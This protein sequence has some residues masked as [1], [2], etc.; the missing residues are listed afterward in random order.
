MAQQLFSLYF[1]S[2]GAVELMC[3]AAHCHLLCKPDCCRVFQCSAGYHLS[4]TWLVCA[5]SLKCVKRGCESE[6]DISCFFPSLSGFLTGLSLAQWAVMQLEILQVPQGQNTHLPLWR[7]ECSS[8]LV[9]SYKHSW[10]MEVKPVRDSILIAAL[11]ES[12]SLAGVCSLSVLRSGGCHWPL[13]VLHCVMEEAYCFQHSRQSV[14]SVY[15][16]VTNGHDHEGNSIDFS[17]LSQ[18]SYYLMISY[19]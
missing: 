6:L 11:C 3:N 14:C 13:S 7:T 18:I 19:R 1:P 2:Y 17:R 16:T 15:S 8:S 9:C 5:P 12:F 4:R 10:F